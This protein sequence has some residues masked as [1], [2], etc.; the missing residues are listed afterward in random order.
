MIYGA[1]DSLL[2]DADSGLLTQLATGAVPAGQYFIPLAIHPSGSFIYGKLLPGGGLS[3]GS[4]SPTTGQVSLVAGSPFG[5]LI[6]NQVTIDSSGKYAFAIGVI[7]SGVYSAPDTLVTFAID[8]TTGA[9]SLL[10]SATFPPS[11]GSV[12]AHPSHEFLYL[13]V[14]GNNTILAYSI[15]GNGNLSPI[16]GSP[17]ST[18]GSGLLYQSSLVTDAGGMF[19]YVGNI[20][21]SAA[22]TISGFMIDQTTGALTSIAGSPFPFEGAPSALAIVK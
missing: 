6:F 16:A 20:F 21:G 1:G 7:D 17:F 22:G 3:A 10:N 15:G 8:P 4:I 14:E 5:G 11:L 13:T 12:L 18:G 2:I 19:L 9:L